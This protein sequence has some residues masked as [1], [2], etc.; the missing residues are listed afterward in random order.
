M[1]P[2]LIQRIETLRSRAAQN[3]YVDAEESEVVPVSAPEGG[4]VDFR[5]DASGGLL[6]IFDARGHRT[7]V[8]NRLQYDDGFVIRIPWPLLEDPGVNRVGRSRG[9]QR[10]EN[11]AAQ[12]QMPKSGTARAKVLSAFIADRR[13]GGDGLI[14]EDVSARLGMNLYTAA[15]RRTELVNM[16]WLRSSGRVGRTKMNSE[17]IKW[18]LTPAAIERLNL[19]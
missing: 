14:D 16:G 1:T 18:E 11:H 6:G 17:S 15:P 4:F 5:F 7:E 8:G 13:E 9:R 12:L 2:D 3:P 19:S 10:T